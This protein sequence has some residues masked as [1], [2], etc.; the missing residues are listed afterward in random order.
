MTCYFQQS[1]KSDVLTGT[2]KIVNVVSGRINENMRKILE[3]EFTQAEVFQAV[4]QM[5]LAK[6][7]RPDGLPT[8]FYQKFWHLVGD[9]VSKLVLR[10]I[11]DGL[12][13]KELNH[14]FICLIPKVKKS[15]SCQRILPISSCNVI[16]KLVIK[17]I[18]KHLKIILHYIVGPY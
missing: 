10:V 5:H 6:A 12:N 14:T 15:P 3:P 16:F 11:N 18:A 1:L 4:K 9:D 17:T 2:D 7:L 13:A 8:L